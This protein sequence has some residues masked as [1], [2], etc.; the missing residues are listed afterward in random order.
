MVDAVSGRFRYSRARRRRRRGSGFKLFLRLVVALRWAAALAVLLLLAWGVAAETRSS[1]LQSRVFSWLTRDMN[2][3]LAA[4]A[5]DAI[6]FPK[7]GPYD[8]RLGYAELPRFIHSLE[9]HHFAIAD[10]AR[11]SPFARTFRRARRLR[12]LSRKGARRA[13]ALRPRRR[14]A[15]PVELSRADLREF[16]VDPAA[17]RRQPFLYRRPRSLC[18]RRA[19]SQPGGQL[20][21][22]RARRGRTRR[23]RRRSAVSRRRRQ[24]ARDPDR[25]I[26]SFARRPHA[27]H[28]RKAAADD[29]RLGPC[30]SRRSEH[31][32]GAAPDHHGLPELGAVGLAPRLWRDHRRPGS[33][34][35][36]VR[37]RCSPRPTKC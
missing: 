23:R 27:R 13:D 30:L 37:N 8:E 7:Y 36:L 3:S 9:E 11:W 6:I 25:K 16:R 14:P 29:D 17:R 28:R 15:L 18:T 2:F 31:A 33:D 32:G 19:G 4:G 26:S 21:P 35:A 34:V 12:D 20:G 1:F 10:Q 24:H 22:V 5:S